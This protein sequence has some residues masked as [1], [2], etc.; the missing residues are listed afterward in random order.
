MRAVKLIALIAMLSLT[1]CAATEK[2]ETIDAVE[3]LY[4][5]DVCT[6]HEEPADLTPADIEARTEDQLREYLAYY[7]WGIRNGC[8]P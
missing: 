3:T 5:I 7:E 1:A 4:E 2:F 6:G 8:W